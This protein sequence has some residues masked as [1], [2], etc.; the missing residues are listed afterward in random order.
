MKSKQ[1]TNQLLGRR[2]QGK[3]FLN[4][5]SNDSVIALFGSSDP[6]FLRED[7]LQCVIAKNS[8]GP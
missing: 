5:M 8:L 6:I 4:A 1:A 7:W 2:E 3:R